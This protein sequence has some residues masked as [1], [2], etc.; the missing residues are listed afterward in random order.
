M[1]F[2]NKKRVI[3]V[4]AAALLGAS[5][6]ATAGSWGDKGDWDKGDKDAHSMHNDMGW[7]DKHGK[8]GKDWGGNMMEGEGHMSMRMRMVWNLDLDAGQRSKIRGI[9]RELRGKAFALDDKI[10]DTS[11]KLF[12]LY[13]ADNRDPKAIGKVYDEIFKVRREK[14]ELM[15]DYGNKIEAVLSDDQRKQMKKFR[16]NPRWGA[17]H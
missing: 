15:I 6:S 12:D 3:G 14:I 7:G 16:F 10:E 1:S 11:D 9:Q 5:V 2:T 8:D 13:R 4:L 17:M